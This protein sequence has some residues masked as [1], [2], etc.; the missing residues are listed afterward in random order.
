MRCCKSNTCCVNNAFSPGKYHSFPVQAKAAFWFLLCSF[1][2][3][4]VQSITVLVYTRLLDT[5]EFGQ[6]NIFNS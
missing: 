4:R 5:A 1:V 3:K 6:Y 2:Q